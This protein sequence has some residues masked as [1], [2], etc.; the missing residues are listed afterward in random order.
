MLHA[1]TCVCLGVFGFGFQGPAHLVFCDWGCCQGLAGA[2][3][4]FQSSL[5]TSACLCCRRQDCKWASCNHINT[6][7]LVCIYVCWGRHCMTFHCTHTSRQTADAFHV[8][9]ARTHVL[10]FGFPLNSWTLPMTPAAAIPG[11]PP[12]GTPK[13]SH[14]PQLSTNM[15][16]VGCCGTPYGMDEPG[17]VL[18]K[19]QDSTT[20]PG[21]PST[22]GIIMRVE[23]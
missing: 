16:S 23:D 19:V 7:H 15:I 14:L 12:D 4:D 21:G 17:Q 22:A 5:Y 6:Q 2:I 13:P 20:Q 9:A 18:C 11:C 8:N 1:H 10:L 3:E